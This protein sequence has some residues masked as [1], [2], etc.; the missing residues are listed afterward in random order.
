MKCWVYTVMSLVDHPDSKPNEK[1]I[2]GNVTQ[3]S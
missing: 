1:G 3:P 2:L